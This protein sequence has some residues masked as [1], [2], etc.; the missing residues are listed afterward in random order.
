MNLLE[1]L[2]AGAGP[3]ALLALGAFAYDTQIKKMPWGRVATFAITK[4]CV[5]PFLTFVTLSWFSVSGTRLAVAVSLAAV[6]TGVTT[7]T[8][9]QQHKVGTQEA[10]GT[11]LLSMVLALLSLSVV[12]YAWLH[13]LFDLSA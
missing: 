7:F 2:G 8:L 6:S 12:S 11:I 3:T 1:T 9:A 13:G 10:E 4:T 5:I